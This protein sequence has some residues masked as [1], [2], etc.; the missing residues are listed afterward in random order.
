MYISI[1]IV[2][3]SE[4]NSGGPCSFPGRTVHKFAFHFWYCEPSF[5]RQPHKMVKHTQKIRNILWGWRLKG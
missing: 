3:K 5:K 4:T 1:T 2:I